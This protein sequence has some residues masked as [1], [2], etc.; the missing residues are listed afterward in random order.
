MERYGKP[1]LLAAALGLLVAAGPA[2]GQENLST[3]PK[4]IEQIQEPVLRDAL[5]MYSP[6]YDSL[7]RGEQI[8]AFTNIY[9]VLNNG[10]LP[11][12]TADESQML[13]QTRAYLYAPQ[14]SAPVLQYDPWADPTYNPW[15]DWWSYPP[16]DGYYNG[17]PASGFGFSVGIGGGGWGGG[18]PG[19]YGGGRPHGGGGHGRR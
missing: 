8:N 5:R 2:F 3:V 4:A 6:G 7:P 12:L 15:D 17:W 16:P 9:K 18:G 19:W 11:Q 1:I 13:A 14:S 10:N